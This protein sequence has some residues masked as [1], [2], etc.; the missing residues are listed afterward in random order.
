MLVASIRPHLGYVWNVGLMLNT[1]ILHKKKTADFIADVTNSV[2]EFLGRCKLH[3][4]EITEMRRGGRKKKPRRET[5]LI[6]IP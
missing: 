3:H 1:E 5:L 2:K 6:S 4:F